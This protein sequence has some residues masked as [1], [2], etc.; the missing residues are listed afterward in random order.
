MNN[1]HTNVVEIKLD[2]DTR[3]LLNKEA[4]EIGVLNGSMTHGRGN[5]T[6]V[7]GEF[8]AHYILGGTRVGHERF[9][10]DIELD[11]GMTVDVKTGT[12]KYAPLPHY[13]VRI[14]APL[15][16][17]EKLATKCDA[18]FFLRTDRACS[19]IWGLGWLYA[20][21]FMQKATFLPMGSVNPSDGRRSP[22]DEFVL[23]ISDL[24]DPREPIVRR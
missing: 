4:K 1:P 11:N 6:G 3:M 5:L 2:Y 17:R 9:S 10:H 7:V 24:R 22:R 16:D 18:Y 8:G 23:P 20:D 15:E 13:A 12:A 14:Y 21:E 19:I